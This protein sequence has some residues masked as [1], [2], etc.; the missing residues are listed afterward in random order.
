MQTPP[1]QPPPLPQRQGES[2]AVQ[3]HG[4]AEV[5]K[6]EPPVLESWQ[7]AYLLYEIDKKTALV[8][9]MLL[10][11]L[12][13]FGGHNFYLK[14]T[15][16]AV[17]QLILTLTVVGSVITVVWLLVDAFLVPGWVRNQNNLLL[18]RA[19]QLSRRHVQKE[20]P[21]SAKLIYK[22]PRRLGKVL[23]EVLDLN[24][25]IHIKLQGAFKEALV[26]TDQRVIIIKAGFM[27]DQTFGSNIFQTPYRNITGVQVKTHWRTGYFEVSAGG[28][29][30]QPTSYYGGKRSAR[31]R[32]NC[33]AL[34]NTADTFRQFREASNFIMSRCR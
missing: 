28:V 5:P 8:A 30:N 34:L 27:T 16:V 14:R 12:G 17:A 4:Q 7:P 20:R 31:S 24:E 2:T 6:R 11:F 32:E 25:T 22:L 10:F 26:C 21:T 15:G 19:V 3:S 29:Q 23:L 33:V 9:Y 1:P 13:P 18:A